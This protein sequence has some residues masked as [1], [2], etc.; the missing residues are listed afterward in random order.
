MQIS[1]ET[2]QTLLM[3]NDYV[4]AH[5]VGR[6]LVV[7]LNNQTLDEQATETTRYHNNRGFT[8]NDAKYGTLHANAYKLNR[9]LTDDE[10]AYW[11]QP[12][13]TQKGVIRILKYWRQIMRAAEIKQNKKLTQGDLL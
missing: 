3:R 4:G 1:K 11:Q 5:A 10:L 9:C 8:P 2:I 13:I 12:A 7:L 6:A